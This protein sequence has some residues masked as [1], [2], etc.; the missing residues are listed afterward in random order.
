MPEGGGESEF[1]Y[2]N[3]SSSINSLSSLHDN[4]VMIVSVK[5]KDWH[6]FYV[7]NFTAVAFLHII[8]VKEN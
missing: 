3:G 8:F 7:F 4:P 5:Q 6:H 2:L 1:F